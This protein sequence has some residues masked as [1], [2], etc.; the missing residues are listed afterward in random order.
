MFGATGPNI[1]TSGGD[2]SF[3]QALYA[4]DLMLADSADTALILGVDEGHDAFSPLLDP[5]IQPGMFLADG[6]S[7]LCVSRKTKKARCSISIPFYQ[8]SKEKNVVAALVHS[9]GCTLKKECGY[10]VVLVGIPA[11][12]QW[13]GE[14]Q[15]KQFLALAKLP[16]PVI[17]YRKLTGE[18]GSASAV[19]TALAASFVEAGIVPGALVNGDD[20]A[21]DNQRNK[22]LVLGLGRYITAMELIR[23]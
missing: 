2:Y 15:L 13:E 11:A 22:I 12:M 21:L 19:A 9:L 14:K 18:F 10:A 7:A 5:S 16:V 6:G 4:A 1:T 17:P 23:S 3:E 20:I 8:S